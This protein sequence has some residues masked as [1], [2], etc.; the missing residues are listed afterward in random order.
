MPNKCSLTESTSQHLGRQ[1]S[2]QLSMAGIAKGVPGSPSSQGVQDRET[3][4]GQILTLP[5][6][7]TLPALQVKESSARP[8]G[9]IPK[10]LCER[11][12]AGSAWAFSLSSGICLPTY[13]RVE[14]RAFTQ[15]HGTD[16]G[17]EL[18]FSYSIFTKKLEN[19][20]KHQHG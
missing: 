14:W 16:L 8:T 9:N 10:E 13:T 19:S 11:E 6:S 2:Q 12:G 4:Q 5:L 17:R 1:S 20:A 7:F 18:S 15:P 3:A